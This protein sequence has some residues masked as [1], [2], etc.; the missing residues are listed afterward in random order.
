MFLKFINANSENFSLQF[1]S[2]S[3]N[4]WTRYLFAIKNP[5]HYIVKQLQNQL[6]MK[7]YSPKNK[8]EV[9]MNILLKI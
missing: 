9:I 3:R 4:Q 1:F 6:S 7:A 2:H 5:S 8:I